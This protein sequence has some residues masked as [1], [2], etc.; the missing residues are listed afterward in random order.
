MERRL[1]GKNPE[2]LVAQFGQFLE[3]TK[4]RDEPTLDAIQ[5]AMQK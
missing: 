1:S 2:L 5:A 3:K 4:P